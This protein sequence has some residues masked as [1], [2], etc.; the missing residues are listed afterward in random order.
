MTFTDNAGEKAGAYIGTYTDHIKADSNIVSDYTWVKIE[1]KDGVSPTIT[2]T[3][4]NG[5]VTIVTKDGSHT[6]TQKILDGTNGT[7]GANGT[8]GQTT[9]FHLKYSN[10]GGKTFTSNQGIMLLYLEITYMQIQFIHIIMPI[11][12]ILKKN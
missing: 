11:M 1:G 10:D 6:Y 7:P 12:H 3:K 9:Y 2:V 5:V 4:E 8:N